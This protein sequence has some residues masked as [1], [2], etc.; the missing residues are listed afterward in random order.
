MGVIGSRGALQR[1]AFVAMML[2]AFYAAVAIAVVQFD[3]AFRPD[4]SRGSDELRYRGF[5]QNLLEGAYTS[6]QHPDLTNGPGYPIVLMP[7]AALGDA[8]WVATAMNVVF[9]VLAVVYCYSTLTQYV[10]PRAALVGAGFLALYPPLLNFLPIHM[11]EPFTV[12]LVAGA[13]YHLT[14]ALS[15]TR[16]RRPP[17]VLATVLF[18]G[19][20]AL[21][22]VAFGYVLAACL[23]LACLAGLALRRSAAP[24]IGATICA[25]ALLICLPWL[26]YTHSVTGKAFYWGSGGNA[27]YWM[28]SP[29]PEEFGDS[30][31]PREDANARHLVRHAK[32]LDQLPGKSKVEQSQI[33]FGAASENISRYPRA[34]LRNVV[35]NVSRLL[36]NFPFSYK[37][38]TP[39]TLFHLVPNMFIVVPLFAAIFSL[40]V[41]CLRGRCSADRL[42]VLVTFGAAFGVSAIVAASARQFTVL[43]PMALVL[44]AQAA[45]S[46]GLLVGSGDG[47]RVGNRSAG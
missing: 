45:S 46:K 21:T 10:V 31:W 1:S 8:W 4:T 3:D 37:P 41:A 7:V 12:F 2:A 5:A 14:R 32:V 24:R 36:F 39:K 47:R 11:T 20:L 33:L 18:I 30:H 28:S 27:L 6:R 38:Q 16:E 13:T 25:G 29:Y 34:Y 9:V 22:K 17:H 43:V 19:Y 15:G 23:L 42:A 35:W 26:I 40:L 44:L